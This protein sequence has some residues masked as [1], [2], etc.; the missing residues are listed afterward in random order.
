MRIVISQP[1]YFPW[2]GLFEQLLL[3][4]I[5]V[6]YDDVQLPQGRSFIS[7]VQIKTNDGV[8]WMTVPLLRKG[9]SKQLISDAVVQKEPDFKKKHLKLFQT[10][11]YNCPYFVDALTILEKSLDASLDSICEINIKGIE[12]IAQYLGIDRVFLKSTD[13]NTSSK[14]TMKLYE[15]IKTLSEGPVTYV[16]GLGA[17]NYLNHELLEENGV[18]TEYMDY[19][20]TEY[21][22]PYGSFTPYITILDLIANCGSASRNYL[23]PKTRKWR[24]VVDV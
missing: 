1:F 10:Y 7:R 14:S 16:T 20:L 8:K 9:R 13:L 5:F 23:K 17:K 6:H 15:T 12:L 2:Y 3:S 11:Y 19:S 24:D 21:P 22:Q 18:E 4:D